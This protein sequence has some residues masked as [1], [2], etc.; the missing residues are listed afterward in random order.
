M[1]SAGLHFICFICLFLFIF[2]Y[3]HWFLLISLIS[4]ISTYFTYCYYFSRACQKEDWSP[5]YKTGPIQKCQPDEETWEQ[6]RFIFFSKGVE[7]RSFH[8]SDRNF[9]DFVTKKITFFD[10]RKF[11]NFWKPRVDIFQ[12]FGVWHKDFKAFWSPA[13]GF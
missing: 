4:S 10:F 1:E 11:C 13:Q 8:P 12:N 2:I 5:T 9:Y 3:F 7:N 6:N